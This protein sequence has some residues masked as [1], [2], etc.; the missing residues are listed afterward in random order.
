MCDSF[1]MVQRWLDFCF[2]FILLLVLLNT[3]KDLVLYG[4]Q[5]YEAWRTSPLVTFVKRVKVAQL[6]GK[7]V[8]V[9]QDRGFFV[10]LFLNNT[11]LNVNYKLTF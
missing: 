4:P 2:L 9:N 6:R 10:C 5:E 11:C 3:Q 7:E 1:F 8:C